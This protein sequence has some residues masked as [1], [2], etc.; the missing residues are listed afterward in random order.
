M[1]QKYMKF[2]SLFLLLVVLGLL[3]WLNLSPDISPENIEVTSLL[4][5]M[6]AGQVQPDNTSKY[7]L[8]ISLN[9][10]SAKPL[11]NELKGYFYTVYIYTPP[12]F[13]FITTDYPKQINPQNFHIGYD[14]R[15]GRPAMI[16]LSN[17]ANLPNINEEAITIAEGFMYTGQSFPIS[18]N[19]IFS[20]HEQLDNQNFYVV[21]SYYQRKFGKNVSWTKIIPVK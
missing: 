19:Y 5:P 6:S 3:F 21:L 10:N 13:R 16:E 1:L 11:V 18:I 20:Q 7:L 8:T 9:S 2:L 17:N 15:T 14:S 12:G 4:N